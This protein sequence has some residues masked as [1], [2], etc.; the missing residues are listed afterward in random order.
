MQCAEQALPY[1]G[2]VDI[3]RQNDRWKLTLEAER[4]ALDPALWE[5]FEQHAA[6]QHAQ[7]ETIIPAHVQ[8]LLLP[9]HANALGRRVQH[10][11]N[12]TKVIL[13]V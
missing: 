11:H 4:I 7:S 10:V 1:G 9:L 6:G 5:T 3:E 12:D 2:R 8:F 13:T